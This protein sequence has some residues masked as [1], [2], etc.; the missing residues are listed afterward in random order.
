MEEV[1]LS[2]KYQVLIPKSLRRE[3]GLEPG[4]KLQV[5]R[6]GNGVNLVPVGPVRISRGYHSST[7]RTIDRE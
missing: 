4:M 3:L 6:W 1:K 5:I 7:D 2:S